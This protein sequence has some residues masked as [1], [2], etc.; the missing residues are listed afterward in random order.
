MPE[1]GMTVAFVGLDTP[2]DKIRFHG[3][4]IVYMDLEAMRF[5]LVIRN[6]RP[7]DRIQ[8]LGMEGIKKL[9]NYFIDMKTSQRDRRKIPIMADDH[10]VLWIVGM[11]LSERVKITDKTKKVVQGKIV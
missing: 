11:R 2:P 10:E 5:P 7:G 4:N 1:L 8:P 9:K 3:E 6:S